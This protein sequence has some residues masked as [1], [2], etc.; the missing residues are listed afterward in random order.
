MR[1]T[2]DIDEKTL[3]DIESETGI[4]KHSP[5]VRKAIDTYLEDSARKK[6]LRRVMEGRCDYSRTNDELEAQGVYDAD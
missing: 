2:V 5:A 4:K 6:F 3:A 1:I